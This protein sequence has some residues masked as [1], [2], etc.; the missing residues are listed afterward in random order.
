MT[1]KILNLGLAILLIF[2][3]FIEVSNSQNQRSYDL[4][5]PWNTIFPSR[6]LQAFEMKSLSAWINNNTPKDAIIF[7]S[8]DDIR[9]FSKRS[10][11]GANSIPL[12]MDRIAS[13]KKARILYKDFLDN[14]SNHEAIRD[15]NAYGINFIV[16]PKD[17]PSVFPTVFFTENYKILKVS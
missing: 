5:I 2:L 15:I 10:L 1:Y 16:V 3:Y 13:W 11:L 7:S 12:K 14:P 9:F 6:Q 8:F 17:L 4:I